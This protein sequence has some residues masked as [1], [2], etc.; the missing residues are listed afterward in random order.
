MV[1]RAQAGVK[2]T[3]WLRIITQSL[4]KFRALPVRGHVFLKM[5]LVGGPAGTEV[6]ATFA[7]GPGQG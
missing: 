7:E 2:I 3:Q 4:S 5:R 1:A 6:R